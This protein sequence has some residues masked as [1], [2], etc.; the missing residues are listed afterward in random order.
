MVATMCINDDQQN[1][2]KIQLLFRDVFYDEHR[3]LITFAVSDEFDVKIFYGE[4][5]VGVQK[6]VAEHFIGIY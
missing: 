2:Y 4:F 1:Y 6:R 5:Y 3:T